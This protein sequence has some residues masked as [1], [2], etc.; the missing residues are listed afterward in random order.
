M[1]ARRGWVSLLVVLVLVACC[2]LR[3]H[4]RVQRRYQSGAAGLHRFESQ[5]IVLLKA[6]PA[7][8]S[9]TVGEGGKSEK[10]KK[11]IDLQSD[12]DSFPTDDASLGAALSAP[13]D[14]ADKEVKS[15]AVKRKKVAVANEEMWAEKEVLQKNT[16][17]YVPK[18]KRP[19]VDTLPHAECR[20]MVN[21][22]AISEHH[23]CYSK[24]ALQQCRLA[25]GICKPEPDPNLRNVRTQADLKREVSVHA[26]RDAMSKQVKALEAA[27][28][29]QQK[30]DDKM[31]AEAEAQRNLTHVKYQ[32]ML[33]KLHIKAGGSSDIADAEETAWNHYNKRLRDAQAAAR[34]SERQRLD[35]ISG[36]SGAAASN[37]AAAR[38]VIEMSQTLKTARER[39]EQERRIGSQKAHDLA[40]R[41]KEFHRTVGKVPMSLTKEYKKLVKEHLARIK[42]RKDIVE[43]LENEKGAAV[44]SAKEMKAHLL[45]SRALITEKTREA[46]QKLHELEAASND[47]EDQKL[48]Y[49][50][51]A[52]RAKE[53]QY[54]Y[55]L[56]A[57]GTASTGSTGLAGSTGATG[58]AS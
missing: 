45:R 37:K 58:S 20:E 8:S 52:T 35:S 7:A 27:Q 43:Q 21:E 51:A 25:C 29:V 46:S 31:V 2:P 39:L 12:S 54:L 17:G 53:D 3:G 41:A 26:A 40:E 47:A 33:E 22:E 36:A 56:R 55:D 50:R 5:R 48:E 38:H 28:Q 11:N 32:A 23:G 18:P 10:S 1:L 16:P 49:N 15:E 4:G 44:R 14:E 9:E 19:C 57:A 42:K 34:S 30:Y 24:K 13:R 6:K